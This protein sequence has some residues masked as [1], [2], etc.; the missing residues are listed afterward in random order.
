MFL[1][2]ITRIRLNI[3]SND[4]IPRE[5]RGYWEWIRLVLTISEEQLLHSAGVD[6]ALYLRTLKF[7]VVLLTIIAVINLVI[8]VPV[9][10]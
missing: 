4:N 8:I 9:N 6:A 5:P 3:D 7:C 1:H 10:R 2:F